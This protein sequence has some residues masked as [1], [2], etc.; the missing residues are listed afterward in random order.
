MLR[1][2]TLR[3]RLA[4]IAALTTALTASAVAMFGYGLA[5][6]SVVGEIDAALLR[7][8]GRYS[9]RFTA[10]GGG[11]GLGVELPTTPVLLVNGKGKVLRSTTTGATS[12]ESLDVAIARG[13]KPAQFSDRTIDGHRF[14]FFTASVHSAQNSTRKLARF[15]QSQGGPGLAISIGH[16]VES[17]QGQLDR[18]AVGFSLLGFGGVFFSAA[19]ALIAVR[20]GTRPLRELNDITKA[21]AT[22]GASVRSAPTNG[23]SDIAMLSANFNAMVDALR[24][25]RATQQRMIDDAAHELRTPLTSMQ[26]NLDILDRA[27]ELDGETR[28]DIV[29][30]LLNQFGELRLLVND[31]GLLAEQNQDRS[32]TLIPID[33]AEI[34]NR[35]VERAEGRAGSVKI[36]CDLHPFSVLGD[37]D[38]LE[39]A[40]VN[41]LDNAIKWSPPG[42]MVTVSLIDGTLR[43]ADQGPGVP[44]AERARV[45]DRFWR[46]STTRNTPG[47]GLGLAIV[48]DIVDEHRG[49]V[50]FG[51][52]EDGGALVTIWLPHLPSQNVL[53]RGEEFP[54]KL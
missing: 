33:L 44:E 54:V 3:S 10:S 25:S 43:V 52:S 2:L 38:R 48:A 31:L 42:T 45:F 50:E 13:T 28:S 9:R 11:I 36:A 1:H 30:A 22:E 5:R 7:D 14:R 47:S 21:I 12:F 39:R 40:V 20:I 17:V 27:S 23:P 15:D 26:T 37:L 24:E 16:D 41:V 8:Y 29:S 4:I 32:S 18:L 34:V 35:A 19:A 51:E 53:A 6:R 49:S 46:A